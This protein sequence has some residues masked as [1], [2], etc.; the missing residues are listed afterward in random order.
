MSDAVTLVTSLS[1]KIKQIEKSIAQ[2]TT[3]ITQWSNNH[4]GLLGM[5]Q[6]TK[7]ALNDAQIIMNV[8]APES[9]VTEVLNVV[10]NVA[11]VEPDVTQ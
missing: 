4:N 7:E 8:V 10:E 5:L 6:A 1:D 11:N 9:P 2:S 3:Q